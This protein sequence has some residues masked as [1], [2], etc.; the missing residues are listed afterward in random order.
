[1]WIFGISVAVSFVVYSLTLNN[2]SFEK[3]MDVCVFSNAALNWSFRIFPQL[4]ILFFYMALLT[5]CIVHNIFAAFY[6]DAYFTE[7]WHVNVLC[8]AK[9]IAQVC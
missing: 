7:V 3:N 4:C 8:S 9:Y 1:M 2:T 6:H 5:Y